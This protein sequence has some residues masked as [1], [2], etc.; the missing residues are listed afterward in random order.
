M[1]RTAK[2]IGAAR[3]FLAFLWGAG[4]RVVNLGGVL[5]ALYCFR[6]AL[7]I[8]QPHGFDVLA[9][10]T[11][12]IPAISGF[13]KVVPLPNGATW[14][15]QYAWE[16]LHPAAKLVRHQTEAFEMIG[17]GVVL[18]LVVN[19]L[20]LARQ[21]VRNENARFAVVAWVL[22]VLLVAVDYARILMLPP[23]WDSIVWANG[24]TLGHALRGAE[25]GLSVYL[26][27]VSLLLKFS[28]ADAHIIRPWGQISGTVRRQLTL[29]TGLMV[30][31]W[32]YLHASVRFFAH[33]FQTTADTQNLIIYAAMAL[34]VWALFMALIGREIW[35]QLVALA[36]FGGLIMASRPLLTAP[37]SLPPSTRSG[38]F[39]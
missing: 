6:Q 28:R 39:A 9:G 23:A 21:N 30:A 25:I 20:N 4:W 38:A 32:P 33:I 22:V 17:V 19:W 35:V 7:D 18:L 16:I 2:F 10:R 37:I 31:L 26:W 11:L 1:N 3:G 14:P 8:V 15:L 5:A 12:T 36:R 13:L 24:V 34:V 29:R 27:S